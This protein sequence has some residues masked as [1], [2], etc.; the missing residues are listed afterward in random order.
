MIDTL[1]DGWRN[2][3]GDAKAITMIL[4]CLIPVLMTL[5]T[6]LIVNSWNRPEQLPM[7]PQEMIDKETAKFAEYLQ[8]KGVT[9]VSKLNFKDEMNARLELQDKF[10]RGM[11]IRLQSRLEADGW[12]LMLDSTDQFVIA[13]K[14]MDRKYIVILDIKEKI[15]HLRLDKDPEP[16]KTVN[17]V[18]RNPDDIV[19][20]INDAIAGRFGVDTTS[21]KEYE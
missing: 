13:L 4:S 7:P 1:K 16:F 6:M 12:R 5:I 21:M 8:N 9:K 15:I 2:M 20:C 11:I 14:G 3:P 19:T 10:R 18:R 17:F